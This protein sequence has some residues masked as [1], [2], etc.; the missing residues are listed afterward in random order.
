MLI[1][2]G[3][4][5]EHGFPVQGWLTFR[6]ALGLGASLLPALLPASGPILFVGCAVILLAT[7]IRAAR[8]R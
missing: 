5:I 8:P 2:W 1:L 7:I 6:Q 4:V 3:S